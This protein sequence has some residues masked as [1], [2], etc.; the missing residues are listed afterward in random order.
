MTQG[1]ALSLTLSI[2]IPVLLFIG[3]MTWSV[4]SDIR[5]NN[6]ISLSIFTLLLLSIFITPFVGFFGV[7]LLFPG[8]HSII[9][10]VIIFISEGFG[11][12]HQDLS[13]GVLNLR[14]CS[15]MLCGMTFIYFFKESTSGKRN[16][17][18]YITRIKRIGKSDDQFSTQSHEEWQEYKNNPENVYL[19]ATKRAGIFGN[20]FFSATVIIL[21]ISIILEAQSAA[22][23]FIAWLL[24]FIIDDWALLLHFKLEAPKA[25][26]NTHNYRIYG[27]VSSV[28]LLTIVGAVDSNSLLA[29]ITT[30]IIFILAALTFTA[31]FS[32]RE[33]YKKILS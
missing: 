3:F 33:A 13:S 4:I 22:F 2:V 18:E 5:S 24:F 32:E 6:D 25:I 26:T 19:N 12:L 10:L 21:W 30:A 23:P 28:T 7:L 8:I 9:N 31:L 16:F 1:W 11:F 17:D 14:I 27:V 29:W 20:L 15:L